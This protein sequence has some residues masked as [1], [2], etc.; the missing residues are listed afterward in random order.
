[1]SRKRKSSVQVGISTTF[2][3]RKKP[4]KISLEQMVE[5][6]PLTDNQAKLFDIYDKGKCVVAYGPPGTGKTFLTIYK[7]LEEVLDPTTPYDK[8]LIVRSLVPTREIGFLPGSLDDKQSE[9]E[10]PYKYMIKKLF[11]LETEDEYELLY[12]N[13]KN[14]KS[15]YFLST[16]FIRGETFDDSIIIVDEFAN[17]NAHELSSII[18]R[19]GENTKIMFCGDANQSDLVKMSERTGIIDFMRI[20]RRMESFDIVEFGIDD[21]VRSSLV[22]EFIVAKTELGL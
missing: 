13:L 3:N 1:M 21:I 16:S 22:K 7:A 14:Q 4:Q 11:N 8:V 6:Q 18:T 2:K 15:L 19:V 12:G 20:L 9:Y 5:L 17:L 10:R